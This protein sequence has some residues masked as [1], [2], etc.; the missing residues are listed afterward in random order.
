MNFDE[1]NEPTFDFDDLSKEDDM[2]LDIP[3]DDDFED[4]MNTRKKA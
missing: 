2:N 4:L 1:T 3:D